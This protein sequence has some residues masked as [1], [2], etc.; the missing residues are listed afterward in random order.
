MPAEAVAVGSPG[1]GGGVWSRG[2]AKKLLDNADSLPARSRLRTAKYA[3]TSLGSPVTV[4]SVADVDGFVT[5]S[6]TPCAKE[7][8]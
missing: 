6:Q 7:Y 4:C 3:V 8:W 1:T 5:R 2:V